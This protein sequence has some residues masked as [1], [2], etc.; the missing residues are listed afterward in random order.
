MITFYF[1]VAA[2]ILLWIHFLWSRRR[3]YKLMFE[4]PGPKGIPFL[5][6]IPEYVI[7][8]R[9][10]YCITVN[11]LIIKSSIYS[12]RI[13]QRTKHMDKYGST[14]LIWM[15]IQPV[16]LTRDPKIA[17][18]ILISSQCLN[19]TSLIT[20]AISDTFAGTG[21]LT[22]KEPEWQQHRKNINS[23]FKP[24]VLLSFLPIFNSEATILVNVIERFV[25][26]KGTDVLPHLLRWSF[27]T[28]HHTTLGTEVK[29]DT[30]FKN[31]TLI[32]S[33]NSLA[34]FILLK[35]FLPLFHNTRICKIFGVENKTTQ[36]FSKIDVFMNKIIDSR[37]HSQSESST[38]LSPN[39]AIN[40]VME[41]YRNGEIT[42]E[43][44]KGESC[45]MV[46]AAFETTALTLHHLLILLAMFPQYQQLL[47]EELKEIF[48]AGG[49][50]EVKYED[51]Q[52]LVYLDR[53]LNETLRL[54][55][56]IPISI[57]DAKEDLRLS[58]G[59]LVPKGVIMCID[60]FNIHRNRDLWGHDA[61]TFDPD[62]FLPDNIRQRHPYAFIPYSKGKRNCIGWRYAL[63]SL[64]IAL[65]RIV[66]N[67]KLST[68]FRYEDLVFIDNIAMKLNKAPLLKFNRRTT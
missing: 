20:K 38:E 15:G 4:I 24:N 46:L 28:S 40:R 67:Y 18:D 7:N 32:E 63:I 49:D 34:F 65:S 12:V 10:L 50:F 52:K 8:K 27:R 9:E 66:R 23:S 36:L 53:V 3:F 55:P 1:W 31:N 47:F 62:R 30:N 60:I 68:S 51:V 57:R 33:W 11:S 61:D 64:K 43:E 48:P 59:V 21:L 42:L 39:I 45:N 17:E 26:Q 58:N 41:L 35:V 54:F 25:G 56:P 37:L 2:G 22:M 14:I 5:G 6:T 29:D 16:L 44:V 13:I 19:R